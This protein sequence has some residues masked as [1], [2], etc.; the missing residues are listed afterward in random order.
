MFFEAFIDVL[1]VIFR[2]FEVIFELKK[3]IFDAI[4]HN[5]EGVGEF[6]FVLLFS[7][8]IKMQLVIYLFV[9]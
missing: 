7:F 1:E 5:F 8:K 6:F 9:L 3:G 2:F 4:E